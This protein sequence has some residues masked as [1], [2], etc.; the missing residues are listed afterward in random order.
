[1]LGCLSSA[2]VVVHLE[3][4]TDAHGAPRGLCSSP[5]DP[6]P[7]DLTRLQG[8]TGCINATRARGKGALLRRRVLRQHSGEGAAA[9]LQHQQLPQG[10]PAGGAH[11][12]QRGAGAQGHRAPA[13]GPRLHVAG[14]PAPRCGRP[15]CP[16]CCTVSSKSAVS[17]CARCL[18]IRIASSI[19][20]SSS[21][22]FEPLSPGFSFSLD[23]S[24]Q[25]HSSYHG[26]NVICCEFWT[27]YQRLH[28]SSLTAF[29]GIVR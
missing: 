29:A 12:L 9:V 25:S 14:R 20:L 7:A 11:H 8:R 3:P 18:R 15:A 19:S 6:S 27:S 22:P 10:A 4:L 5:G 26:S 24:Q 21:A 23:G 2:L 28:F 16:R 13:P 17:H 1:M